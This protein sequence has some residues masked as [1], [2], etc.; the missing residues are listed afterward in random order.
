MAHAFAYHGAGP[1][2]KASRRTYDIQIVGSRIHA[3]Y[4]IP[5]EELKA[6]NDAIVGAIEVISEHRAGGEGSGAREP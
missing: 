5:A 1:G 4:W 6:F 2:G 3:E